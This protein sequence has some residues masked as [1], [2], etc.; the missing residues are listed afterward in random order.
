MKVYSRRHLLRLWL[1]D[2][3]NAWVMPEPMRN[4]ADRIYDE[5]FRRGP[6]TF[7]VDPIPRSVGKA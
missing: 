6:Q 4:R 5:K 3:Q 1:R 7:P 2:P